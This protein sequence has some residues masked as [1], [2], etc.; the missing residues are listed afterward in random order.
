MKKICHVIGAGEFSEQTIPITEYDLVIAADGGYSHL[1]ALSVKADIVIGDFDSLRHKPS[2]PFL[3]EYPP[4]KDDTDMMLAVHEGLQRGYGLFFLYG[5]LGGRLDHTL[6]NIQVLT[7]LAEQ[8]GRGYLVGDGTV[9]T[10][11]R[12][13]KIEFPAALNGIISVFSLSSKANGVSIKGLKYELAKACLSASEP[14]GISN[15][16]TGHTGLVEAED[17]TL[18]ILWQE[19]SACLAGRIRNESMDV[20]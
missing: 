15:E 10:V 5:G 19:N 9:I 13:D 11:I 12:N 2:L 1:E 4:E 14:L 16:F 20:L 18:L 6:A 8:G 3:M 7:C 17:G